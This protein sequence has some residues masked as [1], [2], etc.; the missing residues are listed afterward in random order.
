MKRTLFVCLLA[1]GILVSGASAAVLTNLQ[2]GQLRAMGLAWSNDLGGFNV[3]DRIAYLDSDG[4]FEGPMNVSA[5]TVVYRAIVNDDVSASAAIARSKLAA[6][7]RTWSVPMSS[8]F[9]AS[10]K[11]GLFGNTNFI[12][13]VGLPSENSWTFMVRPWPTTAL[14]PQMYVAAGHENAGTLL[15]E[16]TV[17]S[18]YTTGDSIDI[19]ALFRDGN[20]SALNT[21]AISAWKQD[22]QGTMSI[23]VNPRS[24]VCTGS[25]AFG[26]NWPVSDNVQGTL[27][28]QMIGGNLALLSPGDK[29]IVNVAVQSDD[30]GVAG[31]TWIFIPQ[32][33]FSMKIRG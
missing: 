16:W 5:Q 32:I 4:T 21:M 23:L 31:G 2:K 26:Q 24:A 30:R 13:A 27:R 15:F 11:T 22:Y 6:D 25:T 28:A 18:N 7:S 10:S 3:A 20:G 1:L 29:I 19:I 17:P 9:D 8:L 33:Q 14:V 12:G